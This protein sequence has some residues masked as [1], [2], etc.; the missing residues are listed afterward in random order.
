MRELIHVDDDSFMAEVG[1][2]LADEF[3]LI[4]PAVIDILI[5]QERA[6]FESS[7]IR[8]FVPLLV[9]KNARE[10]LRHRSN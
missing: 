5:R 7:Q 6:R 9:E 2:R 8:D 10:R 3:P 1:R 4:G